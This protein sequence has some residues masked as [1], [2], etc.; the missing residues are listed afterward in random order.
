[1]CRKFCLILMVTLVCA[2]ATIYVAFFHHPPPDAILAANKPRK[3]SGHVVLRTLNSTNEDAVMAAYQIAKWDAWVEANSY[4][5]I[6]EVYDKCN[7][8]VR[9]NLGRIVIYPD[10]KKGGLLC[11][12]F[13]NCTL[14]EEIQSGGI[15]IDI[16]YNGRDLY[17][18]RWD[19]CTA[20]DKE[21]DRQDKI[22]SCPIPKG[23]TI[24]AKGFKVPAFLPRGTFTI[25]TEVINQNEKSVFCTMTELIL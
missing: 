24:V 12:L 22:L 1:M 7:D 25:K 14:G 4:V 21:P 8:P 3:S 17:H 11:K 16:Q 9:L 5:S 19:L 13:M 23:R 18:S 6:G 15:Q 2:T 10:K 20:E